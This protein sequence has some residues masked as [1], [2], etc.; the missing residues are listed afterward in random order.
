M[1]LRDRIYLPHSVAEV[2]WS[3]V[4][5]HKRWPRKPYAKRLTFE[6]DAASFSLN[7]S[8]FS[9]PFGK[10]ERVLVPLQMKR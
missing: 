4:K 2:A 9:L 7:Y 8:I 1:K 6:I 10:G 3:I 5:K